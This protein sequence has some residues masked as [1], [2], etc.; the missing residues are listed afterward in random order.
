MRRQPGTWQHVFATREG[1]IGS[2]TSSRTI[3]RRAI[4]LSP[5]PTGMRSAEMSRSAIAIAWQSSGAG[6]KNLWQF[7]SGFRTVGLP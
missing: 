6:R 2:M 4:G 7:G 1:M 3:I 5:C